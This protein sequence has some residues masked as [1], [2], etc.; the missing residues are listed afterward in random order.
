MTG[1][2]PVGDLRGHMDDSAGRGLDHFIAKHNLYAT[3]EASELFRIRQDLAKGTIKFSFRGGPIERRRWI[4]HKIWPKVPARSLVRWFY[5]YILQFGFLDGRAGFHLC[6]LLAD[7]EHQI[8]LKLAEME[9]RGTS[10]VSVQN[11]AKI[12]ETY[13]PA[14]ARIFQTPAPD[15]VRS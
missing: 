2:G 13:P 8:T 3:L 7:Y 15:L 9:K 14:S 10:E 6:K 4:K 1:T 12:A 11:A 5:M